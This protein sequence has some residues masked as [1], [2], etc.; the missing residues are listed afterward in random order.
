MSHLL[1]ALSEEAIRR[2]FEVMRDRVIFEGVNRENYRWGFIEIDYR[3]H[4][5]RGDVFLDGPRRPCPRLFPLCQIWY[6]NGRLHVRELDIYWERLRFR[7]SFDIREQCVGGNCITRVAGRCIA[8]APRFCVFGGNPDI[9]FEIPLEL[10]FSIQ[11]LSLIAGPRVVRSAVEEP[12][13]SHRWEVYFTNPEVDFDLIDLADI[14]GD[15]VARVRDQVMDK[16]GDLPQWAKDAILAIFDG[17]EGLL[18]FVLDIG[19]N[20]EEWLLTQFNRT[21]GLDSLL[22][23]KVREVLDE[24]PVFRLD[25]PFDA[26]NPPEFT[27]L[28]PISTVTAVIENDEIVVSGGLGG[29]L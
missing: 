22:K 17:I 5:E 7:I 4:L 21:L 25:D 19:D 28:L 29:T 9:H 14:A 6:P 1:M 20:L 11:E 15:F 26:S 18:R 2:I 27:L 23:P 16:L 10:L 8:R 12:P 24:N 13:P 3:G